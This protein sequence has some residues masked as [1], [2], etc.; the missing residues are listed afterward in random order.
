MI[1]GWTRRKELT[2]GPAQAAPDFVFRGVEEHGAVGRLNTHRDHQQERDALIRGK[3]A[4]R[5]H[6]VAVP[7]VHGPHLRDP[8][9][10]LTVPGPERIDHPAEH[11]EPASL[12]GCNLTSPSQGVLDDRIGF[13]P[14]ACEKEGEPAHDRYVIRERGQCRQYRCLRNARRLREMTQDRASRR[15]SRT[16]KDPHAK[17]AVP[18]IPLDDIPPSLAT[19]S[20]PRELSGHLAH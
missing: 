13:G 7:V 18:S 15:G 3:I 20:S 8:G 17:I 16:T 12:S 11:L 9:A 1:D 4:D 6:Q 14:G 2:T 19:E 10:D 5:P